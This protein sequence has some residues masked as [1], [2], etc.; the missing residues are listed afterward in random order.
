MNTLI[1]LSQISFL[2]LNWT[3]GHLGLLK[4]EELMVEFLEFVE[5]LELVALAILFLKLNIVAKPS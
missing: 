5:P 4:L 2:D 3:F 1:T